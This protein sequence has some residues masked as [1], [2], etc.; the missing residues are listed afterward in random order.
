MVTNVS[1]SHDFLYHI[2]VVLNLISSN[3][4]QHKVPGRI[5]AYKTYHQ[6][7][8]IM[9]FILLTRRKLVGHFY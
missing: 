7:S 2:I 1:L 3:N 9:C 6:L 4:R 8:L 5:P